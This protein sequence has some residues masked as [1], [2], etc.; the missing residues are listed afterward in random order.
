LE[1]EKQWND[2]IDGVRELGRWLRVERAEFRRRLMHWETAPAERA[3]GN[4]GTAFNTE[5]DIESEDS[6]SA[7]SC[8]ESVRLENARRAVV[9]E[10]AARLYDESEALPDDGA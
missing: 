2:V 7:I 1:G 4:C 8:E 3:P 6:A 9:E 10:E 5:R